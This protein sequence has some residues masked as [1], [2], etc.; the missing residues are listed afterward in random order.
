MS[1][2]P[3]TK[4][5][6]NGK[7]VESKTKEWI[8][9]HNPATNE[10]QQNRL[11]NLLKEEM[12]THTCTDNLFILEASVGSHSETILLYRFIS[13]WCTQ[14]FFRTHHILLNTWNICPPNFTLL[15]DWKDRILYSLKN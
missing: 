4:L 6:I 14:L 3:T 15:F 1:A 2:V 5:F 12:N 10:V 7:F 13:I 11:Q 8:D 9:V